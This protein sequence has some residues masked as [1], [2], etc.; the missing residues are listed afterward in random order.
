MPFIVCCGA[1]RAMQTWAAHLKTNQTIEGFL[2]T[3]TMLDFNEYYNFINAPQ[4]R[5]NEDL[6]FD[7]SL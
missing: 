7:Q 4:I 2:K 1:V 3:D 5:E 6:F